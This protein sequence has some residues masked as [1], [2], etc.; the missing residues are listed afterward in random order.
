MV[1]L[2]TWRLTT[3]TSRLVAACCHCVSAAGDIPSAR[4]P[5]LSSFG[6]ADTHDET[7]G[8]LTTCTGAAVTDATAEIAA[9]VAAIAVA[10][11][12]TT[13]DLAIATFVVQHGLLCSTRFV[14]CARIQTSYVRYEDQSGH[15]NESIHCSPQ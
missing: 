11:I 10:T 8:R 5:T 7:G 4:E 2:R 12:F 9:D 6:R 1:L 13:I 3:T 15:C 14:V